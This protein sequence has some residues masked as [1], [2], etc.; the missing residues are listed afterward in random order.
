MVWTDS[1]RHADERVCT[2]ALI[3]YFDN[4]LNS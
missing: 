1:M 2:Q 3:L 4:A